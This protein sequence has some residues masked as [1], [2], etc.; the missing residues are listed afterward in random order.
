LLTHLDRSTEPTALLRKL[1]DDGKLGFKTNEGFKS[2]T[3]ETKSMLRMKV[4]EHLK[5]LNDKL[6]PLTSIS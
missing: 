6:K 1:V 3:D 5:L 4:T 2:W